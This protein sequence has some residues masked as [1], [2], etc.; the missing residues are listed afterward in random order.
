MNPVRTAFQSLSVRNFRLFAAGQLVSVTGTWVM[1][2]AQDWLVLSLS[3]DSGTALGAVTALQFAPLLLTLHGGR[4]ADRFDKRKL[5]VAANT[6][7]G[8]LSLGFGTLVRAGA[9]RLWQVA[10]FALCLGLVN[11]VEVPTRMSFVGELVGGALLPNASALSAA[12]FNA[13]RTAGPALA[14][15]LITWWG[16][17]PVVLVNSVSYAGTVVALLLMRPAELH[18]VRAPVVRAG[19]ADGIRYMAAR[20]DLV[21]P[22]VLTA[23]VSTA[24]FNFQLTLPLLSR[25]VF[26][27]GPASFG[28]LTTAFAAGSLAGALAATARRGR[29]SLDVVL[30]AGAALGVTEALSGLAPTYSLALVLLAA[31]GLTS[32]YFAQASNHRIQLG[33]DAGYRGR[34]MA[35]Y[36]VIT[37]GSTPLG[38]LLTGWLADR[39]GA[40]AGL[41]VGGAVTLLATVTALAVDRR[42]ARWA[43]I[44]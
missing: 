19:V 39:A 27:A 17:G 30:G 33:T 13:A 4:L 16:T 42:G 38:T 11:A 26:G 40:R 2:V 28:L 8:L 43:G 41:Y 25:T 22:I 31:T 20:P 21:L 23:V 44:R 36:T 6:G 18:R 1:F 34:V 29:P 15:V 5:L 14:G 9:V 7:A 35:V 24:A 12:Y 10:A 37:Q 32:V 3:H